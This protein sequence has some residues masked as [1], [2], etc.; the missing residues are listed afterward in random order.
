MAELVLPPLNRF[1][2]VA[3]GKEVEDWTFLFGAVQWL[4]VDDVNP[5]LGEELD[6]QEIK[7]YAEEDCQ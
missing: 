5:F 7:D 2:P 6:D 1:Y 4:S 3:V